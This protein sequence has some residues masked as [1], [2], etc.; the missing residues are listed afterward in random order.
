MAAYDLLNVNAIGPLSVN[1]TTNGESY[2]QVTG[3]QLKPQS[4]ETTKVLRDGVR[5]LFFTR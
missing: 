2:F 5:L 1:G 4:R 3:N